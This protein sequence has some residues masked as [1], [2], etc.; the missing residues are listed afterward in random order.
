MCLCA[1]WCVRACVCRMMRSIVRALR[2][3]C[4]CFGVRAAGRCAIDM[5][6]CEIV[7][8]FIKNM[9]Y[10]QE[11]KTSTNEGREGKMRE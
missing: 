7:N 1:V 6:A 11:K 4:V 8:E 9:E 3:Q 5:R 10:K 2:V